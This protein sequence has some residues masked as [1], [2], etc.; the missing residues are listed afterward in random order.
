MKK[1]DYDAYIKGFSLY[2]CAIYNSHNVLFLVVEKPEEEHNP[3]L[4]WWDYTVKIIDYDFKNEVVLMGGWDGGLRRPMIEYDFKEKRSVIVDFDGRCWESQQPHMDFPLYEMS[5]KEGHAFLSLR[6]IAGDIYLAGRARSVCR[7]NGFKKWK[8]ITDPSIH[9]NLRRD[10]IKARKKKKT[11]NIDFGFED[12]DGFSH[13]DLYACGDGG[14]LW[15]HDGQDWKYINL[16]TNAN[17][18]KI[19][20]APDGNVYVAGDL[21]ILLRG[22]GEKWELI[23]QKLTSFPFEGI[24]WFQD[25]LYL[26]SSWGLYYFRNEVFWKVDFGEG[27]HQY[28]FQ[29]IK[30]NGDILVS[31]GPNQAIV[32]DGNSWRN[33]IKEK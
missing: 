29:H 21:G 13:D 2:D 22:R 25:T 31:F 3:E 14:D 4:T 26:S 33:I 20:C 17:L 10:I 12:V 8:D 18:R 19:L 9:E 23:P 11:H 7:K 32:Y 24:A 28:S 16:P 27:V 1:E 6:T 15:H 30:S 5:C